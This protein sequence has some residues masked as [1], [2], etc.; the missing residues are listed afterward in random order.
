MPSNRRYLN[1]SRSKK[2]VTSRSVVNP[3]STCCH[4]SSTRNQGRWREQSRLS[5]RPHT[6]QCRRDFD[7]SIARVVRARTSGADESSKAAIRG[8]E[9]TKGKIAEGDD[10]DD[11]CAHGLGA[12]KCVIT[13]RNRRENLLSLLVYNPYSTLP[14]S[15]SLSRPAL[16]NTRF[17]FDVRAPRNFGLV[18]Q[19]NLRE[20]STLFTRAWKAR[21]A[22]F[23]FFFSFESTIRWRNRVRFFVPNETLSIQGKGVSFN[24]Y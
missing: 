6:A 11:G 21:P 17:R 24:R 20:I 19:S 7:L 10:D 22:R 15:K 4:F 16:V 2:L 14:D 13:R 23:L 18:A 8:F 5:C 1:K 12:P 3:L 9:E